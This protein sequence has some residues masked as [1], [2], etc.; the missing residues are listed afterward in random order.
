[1]AFGK[2][3]TVVVG[4]VRILR[5]EPHVAEKQRRHDVRR[6]TAGGGMSAARRRGRRNRVDPQ[7]VRDPRQV[8]LNSHI[9]LLIETLRT[10]PRKAKLKNCKSRDCFMAGKARDGYRGRT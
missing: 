8:F 5:V 10:A 3:E 1:M 7:L 4:V 6:R 9:H 2:N